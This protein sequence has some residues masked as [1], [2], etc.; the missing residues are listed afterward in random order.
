MQVTA[1]VLAVKNE[2]FIRKKFDVFNILTQN[3]D[4]GYKLE[5]PHVRTASGEAVL[6]STHHLCYGS[7]K[8][9]QVFVH[10]SCV[11]RVYI[12]HTCFPDA[13]CLGV[14][15]SYSFLARLY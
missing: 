9:T 2:N 3:I 6:T 14:H 7:D 1:I 10:K 13:K 8:N 11:N 5:P 12:L 15:L 4:H